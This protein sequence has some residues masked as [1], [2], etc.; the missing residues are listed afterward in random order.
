MQ[1]TVPF[2]SVLTPERNGHSRN[3]SSSL[4]DLWSGAQSA[5]YCYL[6]KK[7]TMLALEIPDFEHGM[8][9]LTA[10]SDP[11]ALIPD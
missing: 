2:M 1:V 9:I 11:R 4:Q 8:E 6:F 3:V 5:I 7:T 10:G